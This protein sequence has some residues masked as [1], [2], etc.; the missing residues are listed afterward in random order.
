MYTPGY[1]QNLEKDSKLYNAAFWEGSTIAFLRK[2]ASMSVRGSTGAASM[3]RA[4]ARCNTRWSNWIEARLPTNFVTQLKAAHEDLAK[5]AVG[6]PGVV[7]DVGAG[8]M[9][10]F[11]R[12]PHLAFVVG[13]DIDAE[14]IT[15]NRDVDAG[16]VGT[17]YQLPIRAKSLDVVVT[18]TLIEHL[19]DTDAFMR[20]VAR[21]LR[22]GGRA[23]HLFPGRFAPFAILNRILPERIK[24]Q[25]L[26]L[27]FPASGGVLGFPA[28]YHRCTEPRMRQLLRDVGFDVVES[29]SYYYQSLYYKA[30]FP[31]YLFSLVYDLI[32][33]GLGINVLAS[34]VLMVAKRHT[35]L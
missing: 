5:D 30:F 6:K 23:I 7:L 20:E 18:R 10:P 27:V 35:E 21:V 32:V 26:L 33:W 17:A 1:G 29:R 11:A 34:Q 16:L 24:R 25:L 22:P 19:S 9:S 12:K 3:L 15:R 28:F 8:F 14:Q 31:L 13:V 2:T 4:F